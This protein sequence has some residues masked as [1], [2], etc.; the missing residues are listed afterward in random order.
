M[1]KLYAAPG[2][3]VAEK[4]MT[5][6]V[7]VRGKDTIFPAG[8]ATRIS[9]IVDGTSNTAMVLEVSDERAVIWTKPDDF[10][11]DKDDPLKGVVGLRDG[12]FLVLFADASV[13]TLSG[14]LSKEA[15]RAMFTRGGGEAVNSEK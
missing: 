4:H 11:P 13:H 1:P 15:V 8:Q 10:G 6:Y 3:K 9:H 12:R 7:T 5:N 14:S 2:S